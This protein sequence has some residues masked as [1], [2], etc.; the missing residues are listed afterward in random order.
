MSST[1]RVTYH[2]TFFTQNIAVAH[3]NSY[4]LILSKCIPPNTEYIISTIDRLPQAAI[5]DT[6]DPLAHSNNRNIGE[7]AAKLF[8]S[9]FSA[10]SLF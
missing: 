3:L 4:R 7:E 6:I 8:H 1:N 9:K 10:V 2:R 5:F